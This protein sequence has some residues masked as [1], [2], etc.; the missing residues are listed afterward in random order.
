VDPVYHAGGTYY[1]APEG[2]VA[3]K[4]CALIHKVMVKEGRYAFAQVVL[5]DRE[6]K[7]DHF[8]LHAARAVLAQRELCLVVNEGRQKGVYRQY[9]RRCKTLTKVEV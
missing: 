1:L 7:D 8:R 5:R 3:Q 6:Q 4:P 2:A 9:L